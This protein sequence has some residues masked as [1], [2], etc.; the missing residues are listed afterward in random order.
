MNT[1]ARTVRRRGGSFLT[2]SLRRERSPDVLVEVVPHRGT[3]ALELW[4]AASEGDGV[5]CFPV[6]LIRSALARAATHARV[7]LER[8]VESPGI[9]KRETLSC[10]CDPIV[11]APPPDRVGEKR[12]GTDLRRAPHYR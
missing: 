3:Q 10:R 6:A 12:E 8:A 5:R 7:G 11:T 4:E 9:R 2:H 1:I